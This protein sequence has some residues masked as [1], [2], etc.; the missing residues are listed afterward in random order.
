MHDW[1]SR[2]AA[3]RRRLALCLGAIAFAV[4]AR[5]AGLLCGMAVFWAAQFLLLGGM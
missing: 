4:L 5:A 1:L 3:W 2:C